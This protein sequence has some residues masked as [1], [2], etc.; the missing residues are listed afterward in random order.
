L[1]WS[2]LLTATPLPVQTVEARVVG[3]ADG[4]TVTVLNSNNI[5]HKTR[6][7]G[8][9][10]PEKGQP[11]GDRSKQSLSRAVIGKPVRVDWSKQDRYGRLVGKVWVSSPDMACARTSAPDCP[12][13]LDVKQAF[14]AQA[15]HLS[16]SPATHASRAFRPP[17]TY[18]NL[19]LGNSTYVL[20][21]AILGRASGCNNF[22]NVE[23]SP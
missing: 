3:V 5:Q 11:F 14:H 23:T 8:I 22:L 20:H 18:R 1:G 2:A 10:A 21:S 7:A 12:K 4:D 16:C 9:D 13:T 17:N 15:Q 19:G 6:L